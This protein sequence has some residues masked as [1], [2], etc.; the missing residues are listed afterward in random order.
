MSVRKNGRTDVKEDRYGKKNTVSEL[1]LHLSSKL[2]SRDV[3]LEGV[4]FVARSG[5]K[6]PEKV[7]V[8][9]FRGPKWIASA[10]CDHYG[11]VVYSMPGTDKK[12]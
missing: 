1:T 3:E 8:D 5:K 9:A 7:I 11:N 10:N 2:A 12:R 6:N 4:R